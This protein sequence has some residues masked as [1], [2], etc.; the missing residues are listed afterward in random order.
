[1]GP[2]MGISLRVSMQSP[3]I[4]LPLLAALRESALV[5]RSAGAATIIASEL[6]RAT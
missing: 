6:R 2:Q 5:S 1:M 4:D 3:L